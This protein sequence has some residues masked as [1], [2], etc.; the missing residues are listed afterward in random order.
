MVLQWSGAF[1][2]GTHNEMPLPVSLVV[3]GASRL[4]AEAGVSFGVVKGEFVEL[5]ILELVDSEVQ[6]PGDVGRFDRE[7]FVMCWGERH[8]VMVK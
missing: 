2:G 3:D 4:L 7:G 5:E 6:D 1:T 8:V